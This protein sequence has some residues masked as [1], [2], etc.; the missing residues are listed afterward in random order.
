MTTSVSWLS[1]MPHSQT[2]D[3]VLH[4]SQEFLSKE[5]PLKV[6]SVAHPR[7]LVN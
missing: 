6:L 5:R 1:C 7:V 4:C 3:V 2:H